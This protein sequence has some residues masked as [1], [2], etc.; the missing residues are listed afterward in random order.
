MTIKEIREKAGVLHDAIADFRKLADKGTLTAEQTA[1]YDKALD[2]YTELRKDLD[3]ESRAAGLSLVPAAAAAPAPGSQTAPGAP[4]VITSETRSLALAG[5]IC[6]RANRADA[7]TEPMRQAMTACHADAQGVTLRGARRPMEL[8]TMNTQTGSAGGF[9]IPTDTMTEIERAMLFFG[10]VRN[11]ASLI[12]TP[13]GN[14]LEWPTVDDTSNR[15]RLL[16]EGAT[17]TNTNVT[18]GKKRWDA[19]TLSSDVVKL[20]FQLAQDA[21][22]NIEAFINDIIGERLARGENYYLTVGTGASQPYGIVPASTLGKT[23][24]SATAIAADEVLDLLFSVDPAYRSAATWMMNDGIA[25]AIRKLKGSGS[26]DYLWQPGLQN[27]QPDR[28]LGYAISYNNDMQATVATATKTMLFGDMSRYKVREVSGIRYQVLNELYAATGE[29]G[30]QAFLRFDGNL[31][32]AG[33]HPVKH[34]LQA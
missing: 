3:R 22:Q 7:I 31:L 2:E 6:Q 24:A 15:G 4:V 27:G 8:R 25:L 19:Y 17:V 23:T 13:N 32:D 14:P 9:L 29:I 1:N 34:M 28:L 26:G 20:S 33:T 30:I 21:P 11:V 10:S 18:I 5:V 12:T 16:G